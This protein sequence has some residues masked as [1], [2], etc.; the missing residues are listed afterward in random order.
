[1][2]STKGLFWFIFLVTGTFFSCSMIDPPEYT[3]P[4]DP[5]NPDFKEVGAKITSPQHGA[6]ITQTQITFTWEGNHS[7][8]LFAYK[9][10]DRDNEYSHWASSE[11]VTYKFLDEGIYTF[12]VKEKFGPYEQAIPDSITITVNALKETSLIFYRWHNTIE[13]DQ[14]SYIDIC[15]EEVTHFKGITAQINIDPSIIVLGIDENSSVIEN[16][17]GNWILLTNDP[18]NINENDFITIDGVLLGGESNGFTGT[19]PIGRIYYKTTVNGHFI[20]NHDL[21][22][23]RNNQNQDI[24]ITIFREGLVTIE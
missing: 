19:A 8:A 22:I 1:M 15:V 12:F 11:T 16:S 20:F 4:N 13:P 10:T 3:N 24:G 23:L 14:E 21:T 6:E 17:G 2:K 7:G 18:E 9:L 5:L